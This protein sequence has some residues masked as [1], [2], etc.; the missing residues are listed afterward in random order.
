MDFATPDGVLGEFDGKLKYDE[1]LRPGE[2]A[3]DAVM[4]EKRREARL[5]ELGF[6]IVRWDWDLLHQPEALVRRVETALT[7][8]PQQFRGSVSIEPP[9]RF[10][11]PDWGPLAALFG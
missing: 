9:K 3:A 5:R 8:G 11:R 2:T 1:L 10:R 7:K 4:R 6:E